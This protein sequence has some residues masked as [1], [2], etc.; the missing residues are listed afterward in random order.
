[1]KRWGVYVAGILVLVLLGGTPFSKSD[2]AKLQPVELLRISKRGETIQVETDTGDRGKGESLSAAFA[3]LKETTAGDVFLDTADY[4]IVTADTLP[5]LPQLA[6]I[7]R[8]GCGV[9]VEQGETELQTA[10][11][12]LSA[13]SPK[14][15]LRD[16]RAGEK[17]I[18]VLVTEKE[19]IHLVQ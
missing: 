4:L 6:E 2:V 13:H 5:L 12:F 18:P 8:P 17:I 9:C 3:D 19:G 10:A 7:L 1:M 16:C 15:T 14:A 11:A